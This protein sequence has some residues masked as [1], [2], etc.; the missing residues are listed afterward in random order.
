MR[1]L[2]PNLPEERKAKMAI[3]QLWPSPL[4]AFL[5]SK[6]KAMIAVDDDETTIWESIEKNIAKWTKDYSHADRQKFIKTYFKDDAQLRTEM[7]KKLMV[8]ILKFMA[9]QI[10]EK[11]QNLNMK[12]IMKKIQCK[13]ILLL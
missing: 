3:K 13:L 11:K 9:D 7:E 2:L 10:T 12:S 6:W 4:K 1:T 5:L 8:K